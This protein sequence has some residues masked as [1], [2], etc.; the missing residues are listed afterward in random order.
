[1]S[2][3]MAAALARMLFLRSPLTLVAPKPP[4]D[5]M[6]LHSLIA[7]ANFSTVIG[8]TTTSSSSRNCNIKK[9][10]KAAAAS[11]AVVKRRTRSVKEFDEE[12]ALRYGDSATHIPVMLGEV[13][14]VFASLSL[15]SFVDC[16]LGAA[17]H[18][19]AIEETLLF[20]GQFSLLIIFIKPETVAISPIIHWQ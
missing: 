19:S 3:V 7:A 20:P 1:M 9:N 6:H 8:T 5:F 16:T 17:G 18:S 12:A 11:E 15:R 10:A 2:A 14:D 4:S 13:L